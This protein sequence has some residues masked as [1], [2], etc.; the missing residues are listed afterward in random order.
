MVFHERLLSG[1][2]SAGSFFSSGSGYIAAIIG[3]LIL[4][5]VIW[6]ALNASN[7]RNIWGEGYEK[8][9]EEETKLT[10][11]RRF[12]RGGLK[13]TTYILGGTLAAAKGIASKAKAIAKSGSVEAAAEE[14][15]AKG[16]VAATEAEKAAQALEAVKGRALGLIAGM[17]LIE[18]SIEK[19]VKREQ[20]EEASEEKEAEFIDKLAEEIGKISNYDQIDA[21]VLEYLKRL[22]EE[23]VARVKSEVA[24][25]KS[26][27]AGMAELVR[28]L[29]VAIIEIKTVLKEARAE[30]KV[31]KKFERKSRKDY[32]ADIKKLKKALDRR[33]KDL[34][35][36]RKAGK[37]ADPNLIDKLEKEIDLMSKQYNS[38]N[39]LNSQLKA[40]YKMMDYEIKQSRRI[41]KKLLNQDRQIQK[42]EGKL[43]GTEKH[44]GK[45]IGKIEESFKKLEASVKTF[46]STADM[47]VIALSFSGSLNEFLKEMEDID[48]ITADFDKALK[49]VLLIGYSMA[50]STE[51]YERLNEA[52]TQAEETVD[53]GMDV[54]VKIM[55]SVVSDSKMQ[56]DE[57]EVSQN[58]E[59]LNKMLDS[60]RGVDDYLKRLAAAIR[61]KIGVLYS[62]IDALINQELEISALLQ[63]Y[64][65]YL[66][67]VMGDAF[68]RKLAI[69]KTYMSQVDDFQRTLKQRNDIAYAAYK[70]ARAT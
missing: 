15:A 63:R 14:G 51:A 29:R 61:Y 10:P 22:M 39:A 64:S 50:R 19:Y 4:I 47:H 67:K 45:L 17:K 37:N 8:E 27:E 42:A 31:F 24:L 52:L 58:L 40:T 21:S 35:N 43:I 30:E 62:A 2:G 56:V 26:N 3:I 13:L 28:W 48:L 49:N 16:A 60:Q 68:N 70:E 34:K 20:S 55:Q 12:L 65:G 44:I 5:L 23:L 33:Y 7:R 69:D 53:Q 18:E 11:F 25:K 6:L 66:G 59:R 46:E 32:S 57:Q 1:L 36:A 54:L 41:I 38:A 9:V